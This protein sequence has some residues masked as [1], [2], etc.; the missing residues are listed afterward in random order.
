MMKELYLAA[1][2]K[3]DEIR[4]SFAKELKVWMFEGDLARTLASVLTET[5]AYNRMATKAELS[6]KDIS[7]TEIEAIMETLDGIPEPLLKDEKQ[8][9]V[10]KLVLFIKEKL[11]AKMIK[12]TDDFSEEVMDKIRELADFSIADERVFRFSNPEDIKR[13]REEAA[14]T[15]DSS[16]IIKSSFSLIN[17]AF[18]AGGYSPGTINMWVGKPAIGKTTAMI[19]ESVAALVE[20]KSVFGV[21]M[22]DMNGYDVLARHIACRKGMYLSSVN[23]K[24][25]DKIVEEDPKLKELLSRLEVS[26]HGSYALDADKLAALAKAQY[27]EKPFDMLILDYDG[28]IAPNATDGL[29]ESGGYTYAKIEKLGKDLQIVILIGCQTKVYFWPFE[30]VPME[31]AA[32]SSKKQHVVDMMVTLGGGKANN[33]MAIGTMNIAKMRRGEGDQQVKL[34]YALGKSKIKEIP[35]AEY[36]RMKA[37]A[38]ANKKKLGVDKGKK[39]TR[40]GKPSRPQ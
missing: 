28:N 36:D 5:N 25:P 4:G 6:T 19:N 32:D 20:G 30:I 7:D 10:E 18:T 26:I 24:T 3:N 29:Y 14:G 33:Q 38:D 39:G 35:L 23:D 17:N 31:A 22:G 9:A 11:Y 2:L 15:A 21:Y 34:I 40:P 27:R 16:K 1:L 37:K 12:E 8:E 13:A